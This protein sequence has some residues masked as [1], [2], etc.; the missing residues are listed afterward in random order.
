MIGAVIETYGGEGF[1]KMR[2]LANKGERE[3]SQY[4]HSHITFFN[5]YYL[6]HKILAIITTFFFSLIKPFTMLCLFV[7]SMNKLDH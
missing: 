7:F 2:T 6:V 3:G 5:I 4:E 1:I